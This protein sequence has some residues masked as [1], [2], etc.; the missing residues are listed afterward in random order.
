M[1]TIEELW[2]EMEAEGGSTWRL[3]NSRKDGAHPLVVALE[4][5]H[6]SR[7]MLLPVPG[8]ELPPRREWPECRGLEWQTVR[9][10]AVPY[11][12]VRLRDA[13]CTDVFSALA[14]DLDSR[15]ALATTVEEAAAELFCRLR[16]WQQFL[17]AWRD[18]M[19]LEAR[20]GLWGELYFLHARLL[21]ALGAAEAVTGWKAGTAAHQDFQFPHAAV[22]VKTT[23]AKQPQSVRIT[24]ERQLDETGVG[25]LFLAVVVVDEREV[26]PVAGTPGQSLSALVAALRVELSIVPPLEA[27]PKNRARG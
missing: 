17:K 7:A 13:L 25:S 1:T 10:N 5:H 3:R 12:G 4:P 27:D 23:S 22:E 21:P 24:S 11:W 9:L 16:L 26:I 14:Q 15:L 19:S 2:Q 20:R 8:L 18:G 6:G